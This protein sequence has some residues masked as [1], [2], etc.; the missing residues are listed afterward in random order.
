[1]NQITVGSDTQAYC[2]SCRDMQEHV[3]V[4]MVGSRPAKVE[5]GHCHKQ[6]LFRAGPPGPAKV[7]VGSPVGPRRTRGPAAPSQPPVAPVDLRA[8]TA[9]RESRLYSPATTFA[10][11]DVVRHLTFGVGLVVVLPGPQK[12][13]V[14]FPDGQKLLAHGR[15]VEAPAL[16]HPPPR[17]DSDR[18][19]SDAPP[20]APPRPLRG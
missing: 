20:P 17:D 15:T 11:G 3:V 9:G 6:H 5:C 16:S 2:T 1:V 12:M 7:K 10:V 4:A 8:L 14:A 13:E 19:P 18:R